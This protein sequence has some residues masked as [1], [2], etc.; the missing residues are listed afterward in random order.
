MA[1]SL[2]LM[3][4]ATRDTPRI[5]LTSRD[6]VASPPTGP[7]TTATDC[8]APVRSRRLRTRMEGSQFRLEAS[9]TRRAI[10]IAG[11]S[12]PSVDRKVASI[13]AEVLTA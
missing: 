12:T 9:P 7:A 1:G 3:P 5:S 2:P 13:L 10:T 11:N 8:P 4:H 6:T